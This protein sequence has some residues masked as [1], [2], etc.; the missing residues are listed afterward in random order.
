MSISFL[1]SFSSA[2]FI[3]AISAFASLLNLMLEEARSS[4]FSSVASAPIIGLSPVFLFLQV[5]QVL[6][7][8]GKHN[9]CY[10]YVFSF[11]LAAFG[12]RDCI[13]LVEGG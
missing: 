5:L 1:F 9:R 11:D 2:E 4:S 3:L 6:V 10:L 8:V 12:T 7:V 13:F